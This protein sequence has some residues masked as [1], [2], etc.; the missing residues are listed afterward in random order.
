M[1]DDQ[2]K[3]TAEMMKIFFYFD[4]EGILNKVFHFLLKFSHHKGIQN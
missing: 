2:G 1:N 3:K 4:S